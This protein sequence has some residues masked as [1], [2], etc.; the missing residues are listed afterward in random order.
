MAYQTN[1]VIP[2]SIFSKWCRYGSKAVG[3]GP[4]DSDCKT[5]YFPA[6]TI[7]LLWLA[8]HPCCTVYDAASNSSFAIAANS[9]PS[10]DYGDRVLATAVLNWIE[11]FSPLVQ[12]FADGVALNDTSTFN[13]GLVNGF[14]QLGG[15]SGRFNLDQVATLNVEIDRLSALPDDQ[16]YCG[17]VNDVGILYESVRSPELFLV[18][19]DAWVAWVAPDGFINQLNSFFEGSIYLGQYQPQY[20][21]EDRST[22]SWGLRLSIYGITALSQAVTIAMVVLIINNHHLP[23]IRGGSPPFLVVIGL[24]SV[25]AL[26]GNYLMGLDDSVVA[27]PAILGRIC[28]SQPYLLVL[29]TMLMFGALLIKMWRIYK[30]FK[31]P[32]LMLLE[33]KAADLMSG[34]V[35]PTLV[36]TIVVVAW[37]V[38]SPLVWTR[39]V[40]RVDGFGNSLSSYGF[41]RSQTTLGFDPFPVLIFGLFMVMLMV[42]FW[43]GYQTRH[44]PSRYNEQSN[45]RSS[46]SF[47]VQVVAV[48][49]PLNYSITSPRG[50]FIL[51]SLMNLSLSLGTTLFILGSKLYPATEDESEPD[52]LGI[53]DFEPADDLSR[54]VVRSARKSCEYANRSESLNRT[55]TGVLHVSMKSS[56]VTGTSKMSIRSKGTDQWASPECRQA[57][58]C[59]EAR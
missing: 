3:V 39:V 13:M 57:S 54:I 10:G 37:N 59:D 22:I 47:W 35:A 7:R 6:I 25:V 31:N 24:A 50:I 49:F 29:P 5:P 16:R 34:I 8:T 33:F 52:G 30:I 41:C 11:A 9:D 18:A 55:G 36:A 4:G 19:W 38:V 2:V 20:P 58:L 48:L 42:N 51:R 46:I 28:M 23:R 45:L 56:R 43:L 44:V 53:T 26:N 1:T 27:D 21:F 14:N 32:K 17:P 40:T 12:D 15:L